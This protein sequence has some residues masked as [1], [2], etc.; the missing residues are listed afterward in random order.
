MIRWALAGAGAVGLVLALLTGVVSGVVAAL[1]GGGGAGCV[2]TATAVDP[3]PLGLTENQVRNAVTIVA[4]G[5]SR[6]VPRR[7]W[8]IAVATA[9]QESDLVNTPGGDRDSVG[10]FQQRPS[11]GWGSPQQLREPTYAAGAFYRRLV[12][13]PGWQQLPL[14]QAAQAVQRSAHPDAYARHEVRA[15]AI[16][17]AVAGPPGAAPVGA[18]PVGCQP[19]GVEAAQGMRLPADTPA[20]VAVALRWALAQVGTPYAFGGDCTA[21]ASGNPAHQCDCSSLVQQA[22][23]AAGVRLPRT[24]GDQVHAGVPVADVRQVRPGDLVFIPGSLGSR[25]NPRHVGLALGGGLVVHAPGTGRTV[26]FSHLSTWAG[27]VVAV[28]RIVA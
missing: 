14:T 16:V 7:G 26:T 10:L 12:E 27:S 2:A 8:V 15:Q 13:V 9:L 19:G 22:Y 21:P 1:F 28:R 4:V 5:R 25:S 23:A 18:I 3:G 24:T 20:P 6:G 11:Q 17:A